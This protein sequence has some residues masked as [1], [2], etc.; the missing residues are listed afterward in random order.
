[1][2]VNFYKH[3]QNQN[4]PVKMYRVLDSFDDYVV[5]MSNESKDRIVYKFPERAEFTVLTTDPITLKGMTPI[6]N[7][8]FV[9][10]DTKAKYA[11]KAKTI[12]ENKLKER[13][14][15]GLF[16]YTT[17]DTTVNASI[18]H[19]AKAG[20]LRSGGVTFES[21][22]LK[23]VELESKE[24]L[25]RILSFDIET[26]SSNCESFPDP[27]NIYDVVFL[28]S[29]TCIDGKH[30]ERH[31][32]FLTNHEN[33]IILENDVRLSCVTSEYDLIMWFLCLVNTFDPDIL[34]GY[35]LSFDIGYLE[36]RSLFKSDLNFNISRNGGGF[37]Q[38]SDVKKQPYKYVLET[39]GRIVVDLYEYMKTARSSFG[40]TRI[41]LNAVS[42]FFLKKNKIDMPYVDMFVAYKK[43]I[44]DDT[45]I[46]L[47]LIE[48]CMTDSDLVY[49]LFLNRDMWSYLIEFS[50]K[51]GATMRTVSQGSTTEKLNP[52]LFNEMYRRNL[53]FNCVP[54]NDRFQISGGYVN[55]S[56]PGIYENAMIGDF[57]S[58]YPSIMIAYNICW[59]TIVECPEKTDDLWKMPIVYTPIIEGVPQDQK[60]KILYFKKSPQGILPKILQTLINE[61]KQI[62]KDF[63]IDTNIDAYNKQ[64]VVKTIANALCGFLGCRSKSRFI[65]PLLNCVVTQR[66]QMLIQ[67]ANLILGQENHIYTDTD[68]SMLTIFPP[69]LKL[70]E[71]SLD[72]EIHESCFICQEEH[73]MRNLIYAECRKYHKKF[74]EIY[75]VILRIQYANECCAKV[76]ADLTKPINFSFETLIEFG[77]FIKPKIYVAQTT[78]LTQDLQIKR[79]FKFSGVCVKKTNYSSILKEF[80]R[81]AVNACVEKTNIYD[82]AINYLVRIYGYIRDPLAYFDVFSIETKF[83][84]IALLPPRSPMLPFALRAEKMGVAFPNNVSIVYVMCEGSDRIPMRY[85]RD[86]IRVSQNVNLSFSYYAEALMKLFSQLVKFT[87]PKKSQRVRTA[88]DDTLQ[89]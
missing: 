48:Y 61:R 43:H 20:I 40:L 57:A 23:P 45:E 86:M 81:E 2:L 25:P 56:R 11:Y 82:I 34:T 85:T 35:N 84:S 33:E 42:E 8:C 72:Y 71:I 78:K 26:F 44:I 24:I 52:Y 1:M 65:N 88:Y 14:R 6:E 18:R 22:K 73:F 9:F 7:P 69:K 37:T 67:R 51:F 29:C 68:S 16:G 83:K 41:S 80:Y 27:Y 58:L 17:L 50:N 3:G 64:L 28:I 21:G 4:L 36:K 19:F 79:D 62:K 76:N 38:L 87:D 89:Y 39:F 59:S 10:E 77:I 66:G 60:S 47:K 31:V 74:V 63:D 46:P 54:S 55:L 30:V 70:S 12:N 13:A 15:E 53:I 32:G 75:N 5:L 49:E